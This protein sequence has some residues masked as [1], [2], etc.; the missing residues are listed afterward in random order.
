MAACWV[1]NANTEDDCANKSAQHHGL[2]HLSN[3]RQGTSLLPI[4]SNALPAQ[5]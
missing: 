3:H 1:C 5:R 2:P 4:L